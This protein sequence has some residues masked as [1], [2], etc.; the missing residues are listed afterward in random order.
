M[1]INALFDMNILFLKKKKKLSL[2][3]PIKSNVDVHCF[4]EI[5]SAFQGQ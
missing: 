1:A 4:S 2:L 3:F 5:F